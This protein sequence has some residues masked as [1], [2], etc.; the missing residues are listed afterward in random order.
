MSQLTSSLCLLGIYY[1]PGPV[2]RALHVGTVMVT[3]FHLRKL[4]LQEM[5]SLAQGHRAKR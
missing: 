1:M 4:R 5:R 3:V 2:P